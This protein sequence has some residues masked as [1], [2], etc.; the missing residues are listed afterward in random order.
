MASYLAQQQTTGRGTPQSMPISGSVQVQNH[1]G[2]FA[3]EVSDWDRLNRFLILGTE[4]GTYY[5]GEQKLTAEHAESVRKLIDSDGLAVVQAVVDVSEHGRAPKNDPALFAL[6]MASALG[7]PMTRG[8]AFQALPKVA[9]TFTHLADFLTFRQQFGGWGRGLKRAVA[10]WYMGRSAASLAIQIVKYRQRNGWTHRDVLRKAH[11]NPLAS[12]EGIGVHVVANDRPSY[13]AEF[14]GAETKVG[15]L[16]YAA[17]KWQGEVAFSDPDG[18]FGPK[19]EVTS[20]GVYPH[21]LVQGYEMIQRVP[22]GGVRAGVPAGLIRE[23]GLPREAV[24][25]QFLNDPF[26]WEALLNNALDR[27]ASAI[28]MVIR[29]LA[30]MTRIGMLQPLSHGN[31]LGKVVSLLTDQ[32]ALTEG[33]VHPMQV[34]AALKAYASGRSE[35]GSSTW[36]PVQ[37]VVDALDQAFYLAFGAV[38]PTGKRILLGLDVSGSMANTRVNGLPDMQ[39][40]EACAAMALVTANVEPNWA[41]MAYDAPIDRPARG[42]GGRVLAMGDGMYDLPISPRQRMGS[43]ISTL[44]RTGGGGTDSALPMKYALERGLEVD[45]FV[46]YTD[47]ETWEGS[48]HP[49]EAIQQYRRRTG[50]QAKLVVVALAS[51]KHTIA[52]PN[53]AGM[54]NVVG[55]DASAPAVISQFIGY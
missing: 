26:V 48:M 5:V 33:R 2:G 39:A 30:T 55:F 23:Y 7:D 45:A 44:E 1:A 10:A 51:T 47:S 29:N 40:R 9:R 53:D 15:L 36:T 32:Q 27:P 17:G 38:Q 50:I 31:S 37:Q 14:T 24:P 42:I 13:D 35:R 52:D 49:A 21:R 41:V 4:G 3:W 8:A 22:E 12:L 18:A 20:N 6:A 11:V 54:L 19:G 25:T 16:A 28:T 46:V 43:V 34:L